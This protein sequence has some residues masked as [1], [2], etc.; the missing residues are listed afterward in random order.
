MRARHSTA[1]I[2]AVFGRAMLIL[3]LAFAPLTVAAQQTLLLDDFNGPSLDTSTWALANWNLGDRTEVANEPEFGSED[4]AEGTTT[5]IRLPLDTYNPKHPGQLV[6]GTE[7][8]SLR[9]FGNEGGTEYLARA[10]LSSW[11]PGLVA[12]FFTYDQRRVKGK[13]LADE[14]DFEVLSKLDTDRLLTTSWDDWGAPGSNY[15]DGIHHLDALLQLANYDWH[16]WNDYAIRWYPDRVEWWVNGKLVHTQDSPVPDLDQP[17]RAN[18]WAAGTT[19]TEAFDEALAPVSNPADNRRFTW[20]IDY[21][22]VTSLSGDGG[23]S[24]PLAPAALAASVNGSLVSLSWTDKADNEDGFVVYRAWKPKG[25]ANPDFTA[26]ADS[27]PNV[28]TF[29]D[30][31]PD[32]EHLYRVTAFNAD[33]ESTPSNTVGVQVGAGGHGGKPH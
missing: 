1:A 31:P 14:I 16:E 11:A 13:V 5:Y 32:G 12:A 6:L 3:A 10:R 20:D 22:A 19:W 18:L 21:I 25:K 28:T 2:G 24:A 9:A 8:H 4:T 27:G 26:I 7:I 33:G 23:G 15:E 29:Q 17:A 30:T